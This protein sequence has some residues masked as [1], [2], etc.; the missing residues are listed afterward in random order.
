MTVFAFE[1]VYFVLYISNITRLHRLMAFYTG[2][3]F[4]PSIEL[5]I[6]FIMIKCTNFPVVKIM[7]LAAICCSVNLKLTR[8]NIFMAIG[9]S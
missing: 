1:I 7:T 5:E 9:A 6:S 2:Y 8:V 4:M 3:I